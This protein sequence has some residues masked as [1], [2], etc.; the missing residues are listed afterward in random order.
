MKH[1]VSGL[2]IAAGLTIAIPVWAQAPMTPSPATPAAP[3]ASGQMHHRV[4]H[5]QG[6]HHVVH[7][8]GKGGGDSVANQLN[9]EELARIQGGGEMA[10]MGPGGQMGPGPQPYPGPPLGGH[11]GHAQ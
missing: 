1:L 8:R 4:V 11:G 2:T 3:T 5:H 6:H 7:Y 10:P 9:R